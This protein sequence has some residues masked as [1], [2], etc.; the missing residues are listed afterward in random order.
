MRDELKVLPFT[1]A[2]LR[3]PVVARSSRRNSI[4]GVQT[5]VLLNYRRGV[6]SLAES[7]GDYILKPAPTDNG[8]RF[9]LDAPANEHLTMMLAAKV[10]GIRTAE[11]ECVRFADG[12]LA[13]LTKR[14]DRRKGVP[15]HQEDLC[16]IAGRTEETHG[17]SYKY[18]FS[19]EEMADLI[20]GVCPA[21]RV[22]LPQV[23]FRIL[24]DFM[25]SNGDSHLKNFSVFE[26]PLGDYMMTP[27]YDLLSTGLHFPHDIG[28]LALSLFRDADFATP[29]SENNGFYSEDDFILLGRSYG[30]AEGQVLEM[31]RRFKDRVEKVRE[32]V[33]V[34]LLGEEAKMEY[35]RLFEDRLNMFR[36]V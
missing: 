32:F 27:S 22:E 34:S 3:L 4:S 20:R 10:F 7:G 2:D 16:Q 6:F 30:V 11:C 29:E 25:F 24:F 1:R 12:E 35:I 26:S 15:V 31:I 33:A 8:G 28:F 14:F 9:P 36:K 5:K 17:E 19:Y 23:F 13:Y 21:A 18:D